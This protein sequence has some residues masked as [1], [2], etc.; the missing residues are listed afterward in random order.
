MI[1]VIQIMVKGSCAVT[2][3][4]ESDGQNSDGGGSC[5]GG[6]SDGDAGGNPEGAEGVVQSTGDVN[7]AIDVGGTFDC[8][9]CIVVN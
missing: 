3:T 4:V 5:C 1:L 6:G 7:D 9:D 2:T 8:D